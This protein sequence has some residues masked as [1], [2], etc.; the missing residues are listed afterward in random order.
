MWL[1][2]PLSLELASTPEYFFGV[3]VNVGQVKDFCEMTFCLF[4]QFFKE[5]FDWNIATTNMTVQVE[6]YDFCLS[7]CLDN[8]EQLFLFGKKPDPEE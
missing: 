6:K 7:R 8:N 1:L 4:V 2:H 3:H 5:S